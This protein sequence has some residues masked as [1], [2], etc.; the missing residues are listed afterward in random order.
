MLHIKSTLAILTMI[1][2]IIGCNSTDKVLSDEQAR[3][4][5]NKLEEV[6]A[7][8]NLGTI[9]EVLDSN[10]VLY[11][12]FFKVGARGLETTKYN[13]QSNSR[14]FPDYKFKI[15]SFYVVNESIVY[16]WSATGTN[17]GPLGRMPTTGKS[18]N[19]S[20]VTVSKVRDGKI[21]EDHQY[22]N[23][24][25]FYKQLGFEIIPPFAVQK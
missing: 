10:Y 6:Y 13:I 11:S 3:T 15:D 25:D 22:W 20:G 19:I 5:C 12:P 23:A 21:Y 17:S 2:L 7:N 9:N 1:V 14:S 16:F 8:K 4:I 24:L 18:I